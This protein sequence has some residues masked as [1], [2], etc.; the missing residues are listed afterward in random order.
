MNVPP[1]TFTFLKDLAAHNDRGWFQ[2]NRD[3]YEADVRDPAL[4][5]IEAFAPRL[6]A[7]SLHFLATPRSLFR[8][9]RDVRFSQDKRPYKTHVGIHFRHERAKDVHA[10][11]YYLHI[12]PGHVFAGLGIWHPDAPTLRAIRERI[13]A[14]PAAWKRATRSKRFRATLQLSGDRLVRP[15]RGFDPAHPLVEDLKWKDYTAVRPLTQ[16]F[17]TRRDLPDRLAEVFRAGSPFMRFL[18]EAV[19]VPF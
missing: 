5:F 8:I 2:A 17:V 1:R 18:C 11:G 14:E 15:P 13:A 12:E 6:R 3:R 16:S 9:H 10:P 19:G 4:A 7:L